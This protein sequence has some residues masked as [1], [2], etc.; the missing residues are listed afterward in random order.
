MPK[1][2]FP[3]VADKNC[4]LLILGSIP[5]E[6]S[7][8]LQQYYGHPRNAFWR[9]L[10]ETLPEKPYS[11]KCAFLL[12]HNI[13]LWDVLKSAERI[14]SLDSAIRDEVPNDFTSFFKKH[15]GIQKICFN[16]K[17]AQSSFQKYFTDLYVSYNC[18]SLPST[19]PAYTLSFEKKKE[20]WDKELSKFIQ[21]SS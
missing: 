19:S 21:N 2:S 15:P 12:S 11:E 8:R 6:E 4:R 16:G 1:H 3:P 13:A 20:M 5:G 10:D 7:L 14:G 17:K 9:I 18:V